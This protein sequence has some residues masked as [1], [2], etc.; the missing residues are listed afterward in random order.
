MICVIAFCSKDADLQ[1]RNLEWCLELD[2]GCGRE[3]VLA[4]DTATPK[5]DV[6]AI[7]A[8]AQRYFTKVHHCLYQ[9]P[10]V[11]GWPAACNWA[12]QSTARWMYE[13]PLRQ[14]WLWL[15]ADAMPLKS[16]WFGTLEEAFN[17]GGK[18][19][20]GHVVKD[21]H[22]MNGVGI[23]PWDV[24]AR[25]EMAMLTRAAAWD[26]V[27][28]PS[29]ERDCTPLNHL[30]QH[31]WNVHPQDRTMI[32]NG[33]GTPLTF[34]TLEDVDLY[35]NFNAVL[36]HRIKDGSLM[37]LLREWKKRQYEM[38]TSTE[39]NVP[40]HT[41]HVE[42]APLNAEPFT[43]QC[44]ILIVTYGLATKRPGG[45]VVS[46]FDWLTW[47]LRSIRRHCTGFFGITLAIPDR[48]AAML[49][50]IAKE[51]AK[52]QSGIP[53]RVKMYKEQLGKG[54]IQHMAVMGNA[55]DF[56]PKGTTHVLHVDA[57]LIFR[58]SAN[59]SCYFHGTKPVYVIRSYQSLT[60]I[61]EGAKAISDC[62]Q[63]KAPTEA[64]LGFP[65]E[66]YTMCCLPMGF[67]IGFYEP[68][69][70]HIEATHGQEYLTYMLS[71]RNEHPAT[72][73]DFT[74]MG[75]WARRF[76]PD[77][78]EWAD[79]SEGNHLAPKEY[80]KSFWSHHGVTPAVQQEIEEMLK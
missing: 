27:L 66:D 22:H 5:A 48:D 16:G 80:H 36:L 20:G 74:A 4:Y 26:V 68:Y 73:M 60:V 35:V 14:P 11:K 41:K 24:M 33:E 25:N 44:E 18:N 12:W 50:P 67:P 55:D 23:Y 75:A 38:V 45:A 7:E 17:A 59:P 51:H 10:P 47:C 57:D 56:V 15:E 43:G 37:P 71:G 6:A 34:R 42:A 62:Y 30:M 53:L 63:W 77:A 65:V 13:S 1:R 49:Q 40:Q 69:R 76:M 19:F 52:S 79:I 58:E 39:F 2:S 61:P 21:M 70:K 29:T 54:H 28:K 64:Q 31:A 9:E 8:L 72:R 3:G 78:F 46:D 32:W